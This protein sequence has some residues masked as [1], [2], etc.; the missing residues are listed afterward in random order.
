[1]TDKDKGYQGWTNYETWAVKLW[2][3]NEEPSYRY[4][5]E[6]A[7]DAWD[8]AEASR[9]GA[10]KEQDAISHLAD[11]LKD[12]HEEALPEIENGW[13]SDLLTAAFGEVNWHEIASSLLEDVDKAGEAIEDE[14]TVL[15]GK[16]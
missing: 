4:W 14:D 11:Q 9:Y 13:A 5:K 6:A 10:T 8:E 15:D 16:E 1:M 7:Q 3:D 12:E 2:L